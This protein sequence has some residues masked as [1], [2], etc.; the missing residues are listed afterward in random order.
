MMAKTST[1]GEVYQQASS[2]LGNDF[3]AELLLRKFLGFDRTSFFLHLRDPFPAHKLSEWESWL[4]KRTSCQPIQYILGEQEFY[5]RI[6][7][8]NAS[9]LIP[10]PETELLVEHVLLYLDRHND[11]QTPVV[12][13]IGTGSGVIAVT[14]AAERSNIHVIA[15]DC[16]EDAIRVAERNAKRH[17]VKEHIRFLCGDYVA[18]LQ[19]EPHMIDVLVS[20]PPYIPTDQLKQLERQVRDFEPHLALDGG[21]DGLAAYR[22]IL[23][24][25]SAWNLLAPHAMMAFEIGFDQKEQVVGLINSF[26]PAALIEVHQDLAGNDRVVLAEIV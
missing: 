1:I 4:S 19:H 15:I 3:E 6:F 25:L 18:P 13:D 11:D 14:L 7:E 22:T 21:A 12:V 24:Q 8:V 5:G 10:R 2:L 26:F 17:G 9:V 23:S 16:S 20:N